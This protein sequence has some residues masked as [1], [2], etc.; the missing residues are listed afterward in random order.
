MDGVKDAF[1]RACDWVEKESHKGTE[2]SA[3]A[4]WATIDSSGRLLFQ[5]LEK[6]ELIAVALRGRP[7]VRDLFFDRC[8]GSDLLAARVEG[9]DV[10]EVFR[11]RHANSQTFRIGDGQVQNRWDC[12]VSFGQE[13]DVCR[14]CVPVLYDLPGGSTYVERVRIGT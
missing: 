10:L 8:P 12:L 4:I 5:V 6:W 7:G 9:S 3:L 13:P 14:R 2:P 1:R 11:L